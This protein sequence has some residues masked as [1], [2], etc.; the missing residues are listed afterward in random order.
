MWDK[1]I[2]EMK[3]AHEAIER[4]IFLE[5]TPKMTGYDKISV[6]SNVKRQLENDMGLEMA[7][8]AEEYAPARKPPTTHPENC[9][10]IFWWTRRSMWIGSS[11]SCTRSTRSALRTT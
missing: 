9:S 6:G 2:G 3:H 11:P 5:A 4:L 7:A 8:F 1:S 10:N